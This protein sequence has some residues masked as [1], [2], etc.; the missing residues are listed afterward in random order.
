V[1]RAACVALAAL[2]LDS[3][4]AHA[5]REPG[6]QEGRP[7]VRPRV[8]V[9]GAAAYFT[10][11]GGFAVP[12]DSAFFTFDDGFAYAGALHF[13]V[14]GDMVVGVDFAY[15]EPDY[16]RRDRR[17]G[18]VETEGSA[19]TVAALLSA[20][21]GTGGGGRFGIY[22][23]P[24]IGVFAYDV[25]DDAADGWDRDIAIHIGAGLEYRLLPRL[26]T[27][28]E[29]GQYWAYHQKEGDARNTAKHN[30]LRA[31]VRVGI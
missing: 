7:P 25:P 24:G 29:F 17:T 31:G 4:A 11:M 23:A 26:G 13:S 1:T 8:F 19:R 5:Q 28:A 3:V 16:Q 22:I 30:L 2:A 10:S 15:S 21:L 27:F 14:G 20:R 6:E 9:T 18:D 12:D